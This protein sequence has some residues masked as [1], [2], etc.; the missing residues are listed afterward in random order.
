MGKIDGSGDASRF[1]KRRVAIAL[2]DRLAAGFHRRDD[3]QAGL[4]LWPLLAGIGLLFAVGIA[5]VTGAAWLAGREADVLATSQS[6]GQVERVLAARSES[7]GTTNLDWAYW[8]EGIEKFVLHP[9]QAYADENLGSYGRDTFGLYGALVVGTDDRPGFAYVNGEPATAD[10]AAGWLRKIAPLIEATRKAS[11]DTPVTA[12]AYLEL[13]GQLV[14]V[15]ASAMLP[16]AGSD[17]IDWPQPPILVFM[18][19]ID[20]AALGSV[21]EAAGVQNLMPAPLDLGSPRKVTLAGPGGETVAVLGFDLR[22]PSA[23]IFVRLWPVELI[24]GIVLLAIG[25]VIAR[26]LLEMASRYQRERQASELA[27]SDAML[28]AKAASHAKSQFLANMS[29]EIRTPLNGVIGYAEMLKLGYIG[30][31]NDKQTEYVASIETAGRHLLA[32]LQDVLDLAKIEAGREDLDE[33]DLDVESVVAKAVALVGPRARE[34]GV[35]VVVESATPA[36]LRVDARRVLQMLLNLLSNAIRFSPPTGAVRV[37]WGGRPDGEF[38][39]FVADDGPGISDADLPRVTEPFHR[40][41]DTA[42]RKD[43]ESNGLG[44]PLTDRL[45]G[46]HGGRLLLWNASAGGLVAELRF[47]AGRLLGAA[48]AGED[49]SALKAAG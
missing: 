48:A 25:G 42:A 1:A 4:K 3:S 24:I 47:P 23:A 34:R 40:R 15:A 32:L 13:D 44:L 10:V 49:R 14:L 45:I 35:A 31:L 26:R 39:L 28:E 22:L 16:E 9:D 41:R 29:H 6:V 21:A 7:L 18:Q 11:G 20:A 33:V 38:G 43:G 37:G 27:L 12:T 30:K 19:A 36:R 17:P 46:L 2:L 8:N 5:A